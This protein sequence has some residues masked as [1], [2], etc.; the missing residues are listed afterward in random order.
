M[1][2]PLSLYDLLGYALPG[3][4]ILIVIAILIT[5]SILEHPMSDAINGLARYLPDTVIQSILY[6]FVCYFMG[7]VL[8]TGRDVISKLVAKSG[9]FKELDVN[10]GKFMESLLNLG[11]EG[12]TSRSKQFVCEFR[13][14]VEKIFRVQ[15]DKMQKDTE[16]TTIF[17]L[18]RMTLI[19]QSPA[20]YS[21]VFILFSRYEFDKAMVYTAFIAMLGFLVRGIHLWVNWFLIILAV[22]SFFVSWLFFRMYKKH[23]GYYRST[24]LY[25]FYEYAVN[26]GTSEESKMH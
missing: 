17:S 14:Q 4:I 3:G 12:A 11:D 24:V 6:G 19:K 8:R 1:R 13:N 15:V 21:R 20:I 23:L 5:P 26:R 9:W 18:C 16:Y 2:V 22:I 7:L 25:G 10:H